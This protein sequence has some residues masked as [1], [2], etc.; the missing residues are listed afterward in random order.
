MK[1]RAAAL[2]FCVLLVFQL[3]V[4][5]A[6]AAGTV[7]FIAANNE[8]LPLSDETMPF[9]SGGYLYIPA[10]IFTGTLR[11]YFGISYS[12]KPSSQTAVL[13]NSVGDHS[14]IFDLRETYTMDREG[15]IS[16]PGGIL[17]NGIP[18]VPAY[19]VAKYFNFNYSVTEVKYGYLVWLRLPGFGLTDKE[20]ADAATYNMVR[21]YEEYLKETAEQGS[22]TPGASSTPNTA[23]G[24][25][26]YLCM[27]ADDTTSAML[28][29]LDRYE[30]QAAFFCTP[31]FMKSNGA[32]LRRMVATGQTVGILVD[33]EK[34][35][36]T[37][38]EQLR[39]GN[40]ALELAT[41]GKTRIAV[42]KNGDDT[43]VQAAQTAGF[44]CLEADLDRS[45]YDLR[46]S[47][48]ATALLQKISAKRGDVTV[49][50]AD[51]ANTAG[52]RA[53]LA[54]AQDADRRCLAAT[55][56]A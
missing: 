21:R 24:K 44:Y 39:E 46:S 50:L 13:Y 11:R 38:E 26:I 31:E 28:D 22:V 8:V 42:V 3:A 43:A 23:S 32:L 54:A 51:T 6:R 25:R 29:V 55:E 49:W 5:P 20:F 9:W 41:C 12:Y 2:I 33:G 35:N 53:F 7:Y 17:R 47:S 37:V 1:Q 14:L 19:L 52:L 34:E 18:F 40:Q 48:N 56:L 27:E 30:M 16:Y 36:Q 15:N 4:P 10:S 45:G